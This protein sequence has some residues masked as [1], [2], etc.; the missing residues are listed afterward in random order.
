MLKI[1][2]FLFFYFI[3][4]MLHSSKKVWSVVNMKQKDNVQL[5]KDYTVRITKEFQK[6]SKV[7][8]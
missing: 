2:K 1:I 7:V 4:I 3:D 6:A 5:N 8:V